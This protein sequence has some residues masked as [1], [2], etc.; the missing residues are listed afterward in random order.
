MAYKLR[1]NISTGPN[2]KT[3]RKKNG[4]TQRNVS[5][6]MEIM[7]LPITED[8]PAK[9]EQG[10]YNIKVRVLLAMKKIYKV[11]GFDVFFEGLE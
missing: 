7:G 1:Q 10:R 8:I 9:I 5:A 6:Q 2:P 3:P 4:L 11:S